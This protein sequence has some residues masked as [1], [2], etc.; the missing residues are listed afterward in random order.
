MRGSQQVLEPIYRLFLK[1]RQATGVL[2]WSS[3][4]RS[5]AQLLGPLTDSNIRVFHDNNLP[6]AQW[7]AENAAILSADVNFVSSTL[8][9]KRVTAQIAISRQLLARTGCLPSLG[10]SGASLTVD[11]YL[12]TKMKVAFAKPAL[13]GTGNNDP[14]GVINATGSHAVTTSNPPVWDDLTGMRY[15]STNYD[16]DR[17]SFGWMTNPRGRKY[18]E[19]TPRFTNAA[20]SMWDLIQKEAEFSLEVADDRIFA[21][22]W[23]YLVIAYWIGDAQ[24]SLLD[25]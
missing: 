8:R 12:A 10:Q 7:T 5:G 13:Y 23:N 4:V 18:F 9:P 14:L 17:T 21:G 20:A 15:A 24:G 6:S 11:E 3:V 16:A 22:L 19:S 1:T 25:P 2:G